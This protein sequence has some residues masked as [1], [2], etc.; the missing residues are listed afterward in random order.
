VSIVP[1]PQPLRAG[2]QD[3]LVAEVHFVG[4]AAST[5]PDVFGIGLWLK[6]TLLLAQI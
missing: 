6:S 1:S 4:C 3:W 2:V 5:T